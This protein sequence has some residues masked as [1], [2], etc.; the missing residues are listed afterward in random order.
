MNYGKTKINRIYPYGFNVA[1][2]TRLLCPDGKIRAPHSIAQ[3][4]D[5][6]F[7]IPATVRIHG[8]VVSGYATVEKQGWISGVKESDFLQACVFRPHTKCV[9]AGLC[10]SWPHKV[11]QDMEFNALIAK[12]HEPQ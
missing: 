3:T 9:D 4:A 2:G 11:E 1:R 5:T 10:P 8:K 6:F 12:A 7:S